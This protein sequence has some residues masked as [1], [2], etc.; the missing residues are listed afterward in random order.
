M[1]TPGILVRTL[2]CFLLVF[3]TW[4]PTG[5][6]FV[7]WALHD[8]AATAAEIAA[9]GALLLALHVLF[10]RMAWVALGAD[11]IVASLA[12]ILAGLLTLH[13]LGVLD[14]WRSDVRTYLLL[15]SFAL[16]LAIGMTWSLLK[17]RVV[18]QS[19]YLSPPP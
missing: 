9:A 10:V 6:S 8:P 18:G 3:A 17:R 14:L 13:E 12:I 7:S 5:Y 2:T 19:N 4:N 1:T 16:V 11:G 15:G